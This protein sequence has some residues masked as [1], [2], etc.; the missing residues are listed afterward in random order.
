[1]T[2]PASQAAHVQ[3]GGSSPRWTTPARYLGVILLFLG[4]GVAFGL[5]SDALQ[6]VV[7][8]FLFAFLLYPM[9][10]LLARITPRRYLLVT[11]G[12]Y[13]V[14]FV[15]IIVAFIT[16]V[17]AFLNGWVA[18]MNDLQ[19]ALPGFQSK[20]QSLESARAGESPGL[21]V[22]VQWA[23][24]ALEALRGTLQVLIPPLVVS[25]S[26]VGVL[27]I[28]LI[29]SFF[30]LLDLYS[31]QGALWEWVPSGYRR[32]IGLLFLRL[33]H[34][35]WSYFKAQFIF[36]ALMAV[37]SAVQFLLM[38]VPF[39]I[40]LAI[41]TGIITL[42]PSIGGILSSLIVAIPC[43]LLGSTVF[44]DMSNLVFTLLVT[45]VNIAI[46]QTTYN[47]VAVPL[48]GSFVRLPKAVVFIV[49]LIAL[50]FGSPM[51][52]FLSV[53]I[54]ATFKLGGGYILHKVAQREPF[55][56]EQAAGER[57]R[58]L[59]RPSVFP[60]SRAAASRRGKG[61]RLKHDP[62]RASAVGNERTRIDVTMNENAIP[63]ESPP[64]FDVLAK[65]T[66]AICNLDCQYCFFL[67][68]E[69]LYPGSRFRMAEDVLEAYIRQMIESQRG[70]EVTICLAGRRA[71]PD[72]PGFLPP[73]R[74][75]AAEV[76]QARHDHPEHPAD[77]RHAA[78]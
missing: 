11:A 70:P 17:P 44:T 45:C 30:I 26:L 61:G 55:A 54:I 72:G 73:R 51:L 28:A 52:A 66:G 8:G 46:T 23:V 33:D 47:F 78:R 32:E 24:D 74:R 43:L 20:V 19:A 67:S 3:L 18:L 2:D 31:S 5:L 57:V 6:T 4:I 29:F 41:L 22:N 13:L 53:P 15:L 42:I 59:L 63:A 25:I 49:V 69:M 62:A 71:D 58:R 39:P 64:A 38:G 50:S 37:A 48:V 16:L 34:M 7:W 76:S 9:T 35:W 27:F 1:M 68:K 60:G 77:Q 12:L 65:P 56:G 75:A 40:F 21:R 36:G 14:I 10:R